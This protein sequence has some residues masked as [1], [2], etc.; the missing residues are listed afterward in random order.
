MFDNKSLLLGDYL[1]VDEFLWI[2]NTYAALLVVFE[3]VIKLDTE[4]T[5]AW[6]LVRLWYTIWI[7]SMLYVLYHIGSVTIAKGSKK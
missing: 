3:M 4:P 6:G 5:V 1:F 7:L 2:F